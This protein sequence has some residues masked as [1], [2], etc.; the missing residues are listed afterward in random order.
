MIIALGI[1]I[2][3][4]FPGGDQ[5]S[6]T[7][8][9][10]IKFIMEDM[11]RIIYGV[12]ERV[13]AIRSETLIIDEKGQAFY[14]LRVEGEMGFQT[15]FQLSSQDIRRLEGLIKDTGFMQ[16]PKSEFAKSEVNEFTRYT[17]EINQGNQVKTV[18]WTN[19]SASKDFVPPLLT[20][21]SD[22]FINIIE[23]YIQLT[24]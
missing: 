22:A 5:T 3:K 19:E 12:T 2:P 1:A 9:I 18:Q 14:D 20:M 24:D 16:I 17:L 7:S 15:R 4:I 6:T 8:V 10:R 21:M 13:G 23:N 11:K